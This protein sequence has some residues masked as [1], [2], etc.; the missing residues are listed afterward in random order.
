[1]LL[2]ALTSAVALEPAIQTTGL[3]E[4]T[5][6]TYRAPAVR[7]YQPPSRFGRETAEG[8]AATDLHR[9]PLTAPVAV[10]DYAGDYEFSPSD[11]QTTYDQ[12]V[13][14][15]AIDA[16]AAMGPLDGRWRIAQPDGRPLLSL[17]L[18]DRGEG[19]R[20]EGAWRRL[21]APAGID[22]MGFAG[23]VSTQGEVVVIPMSEGELRL[24]AAAK[25]WAGEWVQDGRAR[26]VTATR[27][28]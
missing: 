14:Q 19:R 25:G 24:H 13:A 6:E 7:P 17:S 15:A 22:Q 8:D 26:P 27:P 3:L 18:T 11:S 16:E 21:D 1:M 20:V 9:R 23:P 4:A 5:P 28:G 2:L 12:G 10:D